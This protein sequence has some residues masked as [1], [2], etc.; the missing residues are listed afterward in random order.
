MSSDKPAGADNQ[1]G[2][3]QESLTPDYVAGFVDGE[4]CFSV[5]IRPHPTVRYES[6]CVIR[7]LFEIYQHR[8]NV[9][10]LKRFKDFFSC[11]TITA[12]GPKSDVMTYAVSGR[13]DLM[14]K[15]V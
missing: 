14:T 11:G 15:V 4:G 2:R 5:S 10:L 8:D 3:P 6:K 7:P 9:A 12:K 13:R 1:Q